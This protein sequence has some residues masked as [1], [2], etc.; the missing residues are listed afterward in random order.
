M[1]SKEVVWIPGTDHADIATQVIVEKQAW[2][3]HKLT[4]HQ[5]GHE[6]FLE[7]IKLWRKD[8]GTH[9]QKQLR[10]MGASLDWSREYFTMDLVFLWKIVQ[11]S[12]Q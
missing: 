1:C 6:L 12:L 7:E 10:M 5:L 3:K 2:A 11:Y 8:K 4:H 9:I